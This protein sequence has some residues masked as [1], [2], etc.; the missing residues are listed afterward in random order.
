MM[1][2]AVYER[3]AHRRFPQRLGGVQPAEPSSDDHDMRQHLVMF[4]IGQ[5]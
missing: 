4:A 2:V 5:R 3:D 1:V